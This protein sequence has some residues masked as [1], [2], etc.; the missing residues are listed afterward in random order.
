MTVSREDLL[1][2]L[3]R[4]KEQLADSVIL[5]PTDSIPFVLS[6]RAQ[7]AFLHGLYISDKDRDRAAQKDAI[8][9]FSGRAAAARDI[10]AIHGLLAQGFGAS[11]AS[12]RLLAGLQAHTATFMSVAAIGQTVMLLSEAAGGHYSTHAILHRLGLRT[13]DMPVSQD[14]LCIDR[15]ATLAMIQTVEPDFVFVDRSEGLRYED[16]SFV[17]ELDGPTT[18]F[19]ASH[20]VPQILTKRYESPLEW[21]FDLVLFT[22]HKS[23]PGPQK[24]AIVARESGALWRRLQDGLSTFVSSSHAENTYLMG[25]ALLREDWL[26]RYSRRMLETAA[27]LE[28]ALVDRG[29]R[30]IPRSRQGDSTWPATHH[31]WIATDSRDAA[32]RQYEELGRVNVHTNYRLLPY[33]LGYGLRLGTTASSIAGIDLPHIE[34]LADIIATTLFKGTSE[35]LTERVRRLAARARA[36]AI[37]QPQLWT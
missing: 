9:Q 36:T 37:V 26:T 20:Y 30:V 14:R 32:F 18:I 24:A 1:L 10:T 22:L 4:Q 5:T 27:A 13:V 16:F 29:V 31:I 25:L 2:S 3:K 12:L 6:D 21:G 28:A 15:E 11:E 33:H 34:E 17:G 23:F 8:I 7:T 19:D 35:Q